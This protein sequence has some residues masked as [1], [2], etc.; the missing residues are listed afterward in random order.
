M[1]TWSSTI[2]TKNSIRGFTLIELMITV[3]VVGI[4]STL[5]VP[6]YNCYVERGQRATAVG[7][8]MEA[9]QFME[10]FFTANNAYNT[11]STGNG[12]AIPVPLTKAPRDSATPAYNISLVPAAVTTSTYRIQAIPTRAGSCSPVCGTLTINQLQQRTASGL[13]DAATLNACF[14]R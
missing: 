9:S 7:N 10:R 2:K 8:M 5:A 12:V 13:S 11:D 3:A 1:N 14:N 6:A 4:I